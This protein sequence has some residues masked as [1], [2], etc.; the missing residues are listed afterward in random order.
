MVS[1]RLLPPEG[2]L[3]P[4]ARVGQWYLV[5][6]ST[7]DRG[8]NSSWGVV[9]SEAGLTQT[10]SIIAHQSGAL[11]FITHDYRGRCG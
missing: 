4:L 5:P 10:G 9:S 8:E 1:L 7:H 11:F 3:T 6:G 2:M